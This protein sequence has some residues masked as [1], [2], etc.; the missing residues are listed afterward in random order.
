MLNR[1]KKIMKVFVFWSLALTTVFIL[2]IG[3]NPSEGSKFTLLE[4]EVLFGSSFVLPLLVVLFF[5]GSIKS[6]VLKFLAICCLGVWLAHRIFP[7][8]QQVILP[9]LVWLRYMGMVILALLEIKLVAMVFKTI[10]N[11]KEKKLDAKRLQ[12][13]QEMPEWVAK[14]MAWETNMWKGLFSLFRQK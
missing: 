6:I 12:E 1:K 4:L 8:E 7:I 14:I 9:E 2:Y 5:P 11:D 3:A 13:A 10:V